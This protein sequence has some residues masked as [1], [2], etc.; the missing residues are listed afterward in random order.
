MGV[1]NR[2]LQLGGGAVYREENCREIKKESILR[3][4][5]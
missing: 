1:R 3:R 2:V 5:V 4:G